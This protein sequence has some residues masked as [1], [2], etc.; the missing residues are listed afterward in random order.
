MLGPLAKWQRQQRPIVGH[1]RGRARCKVLLRPTWSDDQRTA[2][3][4][5]PV[6]EWTETRKYVPPRQ[7]ELGGGL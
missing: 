6:C 7:L 2:F 5:C 1:R 3:Y 4:R